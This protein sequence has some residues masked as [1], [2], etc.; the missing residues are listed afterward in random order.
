MPEIQW[1][2]LS[3]GVKQHLMDRLKDRRITASD[4]QALQEWPFPPVPSGKW[5]KNFG[6]F[7]LC[8]GLAL[9]HGHPMRA[10]PFIRRDCC[11]VSGGKISVH[12]RS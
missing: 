9:A 8:G 6:A 2:K 4:L 3:K 10:T 12:A 5:Y 11:L 7:K 1:T